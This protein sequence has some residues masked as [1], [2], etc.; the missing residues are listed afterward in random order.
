MEAEMTSILEAHRLDSKIVV[1]KHLRLCEVLA[2]RDPDRAEE[3][4][5][6]HYVE[7]WYPVESREI[8]HEGIDK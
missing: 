3:A 2:T 1:D 7:T 5:V 4:V 6:A 8:D